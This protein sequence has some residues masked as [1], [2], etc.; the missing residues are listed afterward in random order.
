MLKLME[1]CQAGCDCRRFVPQKS[2]DP[3]LSLF[4]CICEHKSTNHRVVD[5]NLEPPPLTYGTSVS[6]PPI[7]HIRQSVNGLFAVN[8]SRHNAGGST[9]VEPNANKD[10][11]KQST[12]STFSTN[13]KGQRSK[14]PIN[15][16]SES[17]HSRSSKKKQS[18]VTSPT[19]KGNLHTYKYIPL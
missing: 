15:D 6:N 4:L 2:L 11:Y 9:R 18:P 17:D 7:E 5:S 13:V 8:S 3:T 12:M 1:C 19:E 14:K 10:F 16:T